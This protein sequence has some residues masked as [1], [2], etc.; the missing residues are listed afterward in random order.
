[1]K[2]NELKNDVLKKM[3]EEY[4]KNTSTVKQLLKNYGVEGCNNLIQ[5]AKLYSEDNCEVCGG[6]VKYILENRAYCKSLDE[7]RKKCIQCGHDG[8]E[9]CSCKKCVEYMEAEE[10][11]KRNH[12]KDILEKFFHEEPISISELNIKELIFLGVL[13]EKNIN[14]RLGVLAKKDYFKNIHYYKEYS[15]LFLKELL[16][17]KII[18]V[19]LNESDLEN[20]IIE[21]N[22]SISYYVYLLSYNLNLKETLDELDIKKE[23]IN[24]FSIKEVEDFWKD[25]CLEECLTFL[26]IRTSAL[27]LGLIENGVREDIVSLL[28]EVLNEY[29]VGQMISIIYKSVNFASNFKIEYDVENSKVHKAVYTNIKNYIVKQYKF[30]SFKRPYELIPTTFNE[31]FCRFILEMDMDEA[32]KNSISEIRI[33]NLLFGED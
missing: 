26:D 33:K 9:T 21:E 30:N 7:L 13:K 11:K 27:K 15:M 6:K 23:L 10:I 18:G 12:K 1:M 32:F 5:A 19:N 2:L 17:N 3:I 4:Y 28:E 22:K 31:Y 25:I 24:N 16:H 20:F 14:Y 8:S 29:S